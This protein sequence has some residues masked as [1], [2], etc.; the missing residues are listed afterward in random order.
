M[1][2]TSGVA[3][4]PKLSVLK[5]AEV[6][7]RTKLSGSSIY[8]LMALGEFPQPL[9]LGD[10]AAAWVESEI[11]AWLEAKLVKRN[12]E[13]PEEREARRANYRRRRR[14]SDR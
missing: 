5:L 9:K 11:D 6:K 8:R 1:V 2:D 10:A 7:A 13:T 4:K 14:E 12:Q 3:P